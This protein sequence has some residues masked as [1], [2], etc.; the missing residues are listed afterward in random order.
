MQGE[1]FNNRTSDLYAAI[2]RGDFPEWDLYVHV[3]KRKDL[4]KFK[5]DPLDATKIRPDI[6]KTR[7]GAMTLNKVPDNFFETTEM[8]AFAPSHLVPGIEASEDRLLHG[9]MFSY[10]DTQLHR[11]GTNNQ[12]IPVNQPLVK[13][14]NNNIDGPGDTGKR[15]GDVNSQP[16]RQNGSAAGDLAYKSVQTPLTGSTQ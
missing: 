16:S 12:L 6:T 2:K 14:N 10:A 11:L 9:R 15:S 8:A 4:D 1:D 3:L 7:I 13:V 5:F